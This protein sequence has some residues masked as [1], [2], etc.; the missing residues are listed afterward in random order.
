MMDPDTMFGFTGLGALIF[1]VLGCWTLYRRTVRAIEPR[2]VSSFKPK[3]LRGS[4][5]LRR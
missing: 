1:V 5:Y 2:S 3:S 4:D